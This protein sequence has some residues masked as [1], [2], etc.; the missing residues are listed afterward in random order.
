[1]QAKRTL[2]PGQDGTKQLL[3]KFGDQLFCVRYRYDP[4]RQVRLKTVELI[5]ETTPWTH[6]SKAIPS[7]SAVL[8]KI[9]LHE[10]D[11]QT[12]VRQ[13]GG[14]W[15]PELRGLVLRYENVLALGLESRIDHSSLLTKRKPRENRPAK[16]SV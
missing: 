8:L 13:A 14:T 7:D 6:R 11:L 3:K 15:D 5:I 1:M 9:S 4:T 10:V 16:R 2:R 12:K